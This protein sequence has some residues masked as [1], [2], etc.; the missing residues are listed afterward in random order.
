MT[1][2]LCEGWVVERRR[3]STHS[4]NIHGG[5]AL[6]LD[7]ELHEDLWGAQV[8]LKSLAPTHPVIS[9]F[10]AAFS[11]GLEEPSLGGA[12]R[13]SGWGTL[14]LEL[15]GQCNERCVHCYASSSP[16]VSQA[17]SW[18]QIRGVLE[19]ARVLGFHDV[20]FTG[21]DP[22]ISQHLTSAVELA[23]SLGFAS[24]EAYTNGLAFRDELAG[25]FSAH[26][27]G[28]AL[29]LYSHDAKV[30][31]RVTNTPGS[32][33]RT[34]DAIRRALA[35]GLRVRVAGIQGCDN[36]QDQ[37]KLVDYLLALGVHEGQISLDLQ[38]PVGRGTFA[39]DVEIRTVRGT[40]HSLAGLT[41]RG[42]LCVSYSGDV[43]PCI[44]DRSTKFGSVREFSLCEILQQ[45]IAVDSRG[46]RHLKLAEGALACGSCRNRR[47]LLERSRW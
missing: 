27:V 2:Q 23:S 4:F 5:E 24:L 25:L 46:P 33:V 13:G 34:S 16:E 1:A 20:Q 32:H 42:K 43:I 10:L 9:E 37:G 41:D 30:H 17:L 45:P 6:Q 31:D 28:M 35:R 14:F 39:T 26:D 7:G 3:S 11:K 12:L 47:E 8:L 29:S 15:T 40:G 21:G 18:E 36:E 22:L 44:F 38:R 19:A